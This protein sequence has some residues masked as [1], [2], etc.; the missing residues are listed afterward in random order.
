MY[1]VIKLVKFYKE[2]RVWFCFILIVFYL[3]IFAYF[4]NKLLFFFQRLF[5]FI[6]ILNFYLIIKS[7]YFF[8]CLPFFEAII[9]NFFFKHF[10]INKFCLFILKWSNLFYIYND[11]LLIIIKYMSFI[12]FF[13]NKYCNTKIKF[14]FSFF[15]VSIYFLFFIIIRNIIIILVLKLKNS[16]KQLIESKFIDF[17][18]KRI[19]IWIVI[20]YFILY[21]AIYFNIFYLIL[22]YLF[23]I[24]I[25]SFKLNKKDIQDF[26]I[27]E[28][29]RLNILND[30]NL[31]FLNKKHSYIYDKFAETIYIFKH[32]NF[33]S[34]ENNLFKF[35]IIATSK[36]IDYNNIAE[37][38]C[39]NEIFYGYQ[40]DLYFMEQCKNNLFFLLINQVLYLLKLNIIYII[41]INTE[42]NFNKKLNEDKKFFLFSQKKKYEDNLLILKKFFNYIDIHEINYSI[43]LC[44]IELEIVDSMDNIIKKTIELRFNCENKIKID[45]LN[46]DILYNYYKIFYNNLCELVNLEN[47]YIYLEISTN[48]INFCYVESWSVISNLEWFTK[49]DNGEITEIEFEKEQD[50]YNKKNI[51]IYFFEYYLSNYVKIN[52]ISKFIYH[53]GLI[54]FEDLLNQNR[55]LKFQY[56]KLKYINFLKNYLKKWKKKKK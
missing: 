24:I 22:F 46:F 31:I 16:K 44:D 6:C 21:F 18:K 23:Y 49:L 26:K 7:F 36:L 13:I 9:K 45:N 20:T 27:S 51:Y 48:M 34:V 28:N 4:L 29:M 47:N 5:I 38:K 35:N 41:R 8:L 1:K 30:S 17:I 56:I 33:N 42:L 25:L 37:L 40:Y 54:S 39:Y 14:Y 52:K 55:K 50:Y 43:S 11:I 12:R 10:F 19:L 53:H 15:D 32:C 3:F 2:Y